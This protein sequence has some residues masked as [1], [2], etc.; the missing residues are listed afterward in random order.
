MSQMNTYFTY[1]SPFVIHS[2]LPNSI[3]YIYILDL[4]QLT[5]KC[6]LERLLFSYL[7]STIAWCL[8]SGLIADYALASQVAFSML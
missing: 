2:N 1:K 6:P 7:T 4:L 5:I 3:L 8:T